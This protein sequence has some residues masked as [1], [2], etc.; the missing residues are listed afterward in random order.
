M[1]R[2]VTQVNII[3]TLLFILK[4]IENKERVNCK[5]KLPSLIFVEEAKPRSDI[6]RAETKP[7][8]LRTWELS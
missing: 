3:R 7:Q 4:S 5:S 6:Q 1:H 2:K 8:I